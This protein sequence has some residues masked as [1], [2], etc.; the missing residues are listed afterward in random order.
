[1]ESNTASLV[2]FG[3]YALDV[4]TGE[5]LRGATSLKLQPQPAKVLTILVRRAGQVAQPPTAGLPLVYVAW[6]L[7]T[8]FLLSSGHFNTDAACRTG[9]LLRRLRST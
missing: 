3:D 9:V 7:T 4:R 2:R 1:M 8:L 5:L 6:A